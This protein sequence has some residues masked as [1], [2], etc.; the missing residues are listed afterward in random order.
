MN[1]GRTVV[2]ARFCFVSITHTALFCVASHLLAISSAQFCS[3][4]R[5]GMHLHPESSAS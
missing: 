2:P 5:L 4:Q 1:K 3:F